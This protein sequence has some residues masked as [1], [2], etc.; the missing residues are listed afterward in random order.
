MRIINL[1]SLVSHCIATELA[2][3]VYCGLGFR[4]EPIFTTALTA[5]INEAQFKSEPEPEPN[6]TETK[7]ITLKPKP[8]PKTDLS[9]N[10]NRNRNRNQNWTELTHNTYSI[11][12]FKGNFFILFMFS[13]HTWKQ[14]DK[15]KLSFTKLV[16]KLKDFDWKDQKISKFWL[17]FEPKF[18]PK[19]KSQSLAETETGIS[20][21]V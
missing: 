2:K 7:F 19:P 10:R 14:A 8:E 20:V 3:F 18:R 11:P 4:L 12:Y 21:Q 17:T 9:R 15:K 1:F 16:H 6:R 5:S 13:I